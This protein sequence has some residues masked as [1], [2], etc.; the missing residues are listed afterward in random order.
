MKARCLQKKAINKFLHAGVL[1][2][3]GCLLFVFFLPP[4]LSAQMDHSDKPD[5]AKKCAIC[6]FQWVYAFYS[7]HRDGE[8]MPKPKQA[9]VATRQM[10]FSCHDG[11]VADSRNNV[12]NCAGHKA[13]VIPSE[14]VTI[15]VDFPL[16]DERKMQCFTCH[17][18]HAISSGSGMG[19][20]VFLRAPNENSSFCKMCHKNKTGG[21]AK[22][23]HS[24]DVGSKKRPLEITK[25]GGRFGTAF[26][27]QV[28]CE[29]CHL[30]HGGL[31]NKFLVLSVEDPKTRSV[32]CETC[33]TDKPGLA[34]DPVLNRFSHPMD[35]T[36]GKPVK[37][38]RKWKGGG[39]VVLGT[40]GELVCRT[41]HTP[42]GAVD[43]KTLLA[44]ENHKDSLC[45]QCHR[46]QKMISGSRH[47][48]R[49][50]MPG[51]ENIMG[52]RA[53]DT[54]PCSPCHLV[55]SG[56]A[57]L[58]WARK[59]V[60]N[61]KPG[62]FCVSCHRS[63]GCSEKVIPEDFSH[64]MDISVESMNFFRSLIKIRCSTCH[65]FHNPFPLYDDPVEKGKKHGKFLL[66][67]NE[68]ASGK[69]I[70]CHPRYGLIKG[71]DHDLSITAPGFKNVSGQTPAQGGICSPCHVAHNANL[72]KY[73]WAAPV[74]PN[75]LEGWD[76][77][78][79]TD[80]DIMI[81]LCTGCHSPGKIAETHVPEFG[82]HPREK[83]MQG[84]PMISYDHLKDEFP[85][86]TDTGETAETG[87][88]VCSSCHNP[89]QWDPH[90]EAKGPG[91]KV[92]GDVTNSFLRS[93][94]HLKYC[95]G[96]HGEE[97]L[98]KFKYFHDHIGRVKKNN[99]SHQ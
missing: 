25:N 27:N 23:N 50:S 17:T 54:G 93:D 38:P 37:I 31:N 39:D 35:L 20:G 12:F 34:K 28:I 66:L 46:D 57:K 82:L 89:H 41:C 69:C 13:G 75:L 8:L 32:L 85:I 83:L 44:E 78:S 52:D 42:H 58:M 45:I 67:S 91:R 10:C 33:H 68:G 84:M 15:P 88:I 48:L 95:T 59:E 74:G 47:D 80:R 29:T 43:S 72:K 70:D 3:F 97:G 77:A 30:A 22:G 53:A 86:F 94:L 90:V 98:V 55:H 64:P 24:V 56:S 99:S 62:M 51:A 87:N 96:C 16:D 18:P 92:E 2:C 79:T 21:F 71:T 7:E 19:I 5:T 26:A 60:I 81:R 76:K 63:G 4:V 6:H 9:A 73:L 11:S 65:D 49:V 1:F 14:N 36:P 40:D 61:E